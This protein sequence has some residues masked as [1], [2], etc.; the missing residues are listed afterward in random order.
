MPTVLPPADD[1][2]PDPSLVPTHVAF[3]QEILDEV[4]R[5]RTEYLAIE[6]ARLVHATPLGAGA[7]VAL[8]AMS[9]LLIA[10]RATFASIRA[11]RDTVV[12]ER[13]FNAVANPVGSTEAE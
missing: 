6:E 4:N 11:A 1:P 7:L 9:D 12:R 2:S 8:E 13:D 3:E 10:S 5:V